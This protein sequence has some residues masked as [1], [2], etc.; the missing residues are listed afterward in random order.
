MEP[1]TFAFHNLTDS[2]KTRVREFMDIVVG[3][4]IH[5]M[6]DGSAELHFDDEGLLQEICLKQKRRR[7]AGEQLTILPRQRANITAAFDPQGEI[8]HLTI[9]TKW[10]RKFA[11]TKPNGTI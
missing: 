9:E 6:R 5:T 1:L 4:G 10:I 2:Q 8:G 3:Q 7:R 11:L